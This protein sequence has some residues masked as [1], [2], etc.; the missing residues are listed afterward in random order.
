[1]VGDR[2]NPVLGGWFEDGLMGRSVGLL[3]IGL[4]SLF[5]V[6]TGVAQAAPETIAGSGMGAGQVLTPRGTAV[7]Q[8]TGNLYVADFNFLGSNGGS[9]AR[10]SKFDSEGHFLLA[11]GWGVA[12]ESSELQTCGPEA[13][14]PTGECFTAPN[15]GSASGPGAILPV[16]VAVDQSSGAVYVVDRLLRRV[17][18]FSSSGEFLFMVGKGVNQ[19]GGTPSSPGNIC[20]AEHLENGDTCG[21]GGSG[22]GP[23]EFSGPQSLAVDSSGVVWVGDEDR[24]ASF[25]SSGAAGPEISLTGAGATNSLALDSA[26]NF[27]VK[28]SL[29]EGI[30]KLEAGT[31]AL[32]ETL[33]VAGQPRA[34]TLD[35]ADNVYIGD[36]TSPYRF[37]VFNPAGEQFLE[38]GAGEVIGN[39]EGNA[40]AIGGD[41]ERLYVASNRSSESE[42]V[43]QAFPLPESGP[44]VEEQRAE[45]VLPTSAT[46]AAR[47]N[48]END[49][50][51]YRFEYGTSASYDQSTPTETLLASGFEGEEVEADL[52]QLLPETT[53]HFRVVASNHCNP[54]EP[55]EVCT[56][57]G[58]DQTFTT[59]PAVVIDPQWASDI[60]DHSVIL[61]AEMDSL[62]V[63]AEAWL[64]YGT[65]EGYGQI[66]PLAN[67]GAGFGPITRQAFLTGLQAATTYYYRFVARDER[68]GITHTVHGLDHAFTTQFG[69]LGFELADDR[70][71]EMVS[72]PDK[73]GAR[74][75][76]GGQYHIQASADGEGLAYLSKQPTEVDPGGNRVPERSMS[77]ARRNADGSWSSRDISPP[78]DSVTPV[79]IGAGAE[80]KLFNPDL[81]EALVEPRSGT[82]LSPEASERTPYLRKNTDPFSY[83]PLVTGK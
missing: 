65:S 31:G 14:P 32:L 60:T 16:A 2:R 30:R 10:I 29:L 64:E 43:V 20:T 71:W 44:L 36:Q 22:T 58:E 80:Y 42:R 54:S 35:E 75:T 8:S 25:S 57:E 11:W 7:H 15:A 1:M 4:V 50:T 12:D 62:G 56:A 38:F 49:E 9:T 19:G 73:S 63:E 27:F 41:A 67:L 23:N 81:A 77:L 52:T 39:P 70:V 72:P 59:P 28:S 83:R 6:F 26:G 74:L 33:D 17:T 21:T 34:V 76:G 48:P 18:K 51:T 69:G 24:I 68:D 82:L 37:K 45:D 78:N 3:A 53:Y 47:I 61:H 40:L 5:A 79:P 66:V 55:A 46:L 13:T